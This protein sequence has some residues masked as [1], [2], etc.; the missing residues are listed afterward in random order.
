MEGRVFL[1]GKPK[2][3]CHA[4]A[5][6]NLVR[7]V[8]QHAAFAPLVLDLLRRSKTDDCPQMRSE[9]FGELRAT[10]MLSGSDCSRAAEELSNL[11]AD[12][13][14]TKIK[15]E[16][17]RGLVVE[18]VAYLA[19]AQMP[20]SCVKHSCRI[21]MKGVPAMQADDESATNL[22]VAGLS[23]CAFKGFEC[24]AS[25]ANFVPCGMDKASWKGS[26]VRKLEYMTM[27]DLCLTNAGV[28]TELCLLSL[29][30]AETHCDRAVKQA[31]GTAGFG[32]IK[33]LNAEN[34][35]RIMTL[36]TRKP[37]AVT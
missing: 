37:E 27:I 31:L 2:A 7:F 4:S 3:P 20:G 11:L 18:Y 22:D 24:K 1:R 29:D 19:C 36:C 13:Y 30:R 25:L 9:Q 17:L 8:A 16:D 32:R 33:V 34:M 28:N 26:V 10:Y 35:E 14:S 12:L 6:V 15:G 5:V 21:G 23:A